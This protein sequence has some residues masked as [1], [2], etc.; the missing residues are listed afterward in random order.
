MFLETGIK[1]SSFFCKNNRRKVEYLQ[2]VYIPIFLE[3]NN[4]RK[5]AF[6]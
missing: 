6:L 5:Y 3:K 1:T 2:Y 4:R